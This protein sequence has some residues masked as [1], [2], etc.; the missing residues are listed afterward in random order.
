MKKNKSKGISYEET[1][2]NKKLEEFEE[3]EEKDA[4]IRGKT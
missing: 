2:K 1:K 4:N 3:K